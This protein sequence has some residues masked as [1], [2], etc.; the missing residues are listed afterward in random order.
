M[1]STAGTPTT[2]LPD[3][4]ATKPSHPLV[5]WLKTRAAWILILDILLVV[6][7]TLLSRDHVFGSVANAQSLL[8]SVSQVMLLALGLAMMLGAGIFDLSLGA[9]LVLSSV[10]GALV[11]RQFQ[12]TP[13]DLTSYHDIG[14]ATVLGLLACIAT[15]AL[16]G[17]VNGVFIAVF[18]INSLISTLATMGIGTGVALLV[19]GGSDISGMPPS[20]QLDIGL[21]MIG[22]VPVPA[23]AALVTAV[24]LWLVVRYTRYGLRVQGIGSSSIAAERAGIR[25]PRY[26]FSLTLLG[27]V[28]AGIAGFIDLTRF[29]S[30]AIA[31]HANDGLGA[32]TA[33]VIGGTL[34]EGGRISI[35]GAV[36]GTG[37]AVIL[38]TGLV[39]VGVSAFW[40]LI[41][42]GVV[43]LGA[44]VL[45]RFAA[46]RRRTKTTTE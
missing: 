38:Q 29:S 24:I 33:A 31:G 14:T 7:F 6:F 10:M 1:T 17:L 2:R 44:V 30:T 25:V 16:F 3:D 26:L 39:I 28:L 22:I 45:D 11:I 8:L 21:K 42:V 20:L 41:V 4:R 9:N 34:L 18:K 12:S 15:G 23:I 43:L 46:V 13:G 35:T 32:V 37:L 36:W 40:Q 19:T 5:R 27:G